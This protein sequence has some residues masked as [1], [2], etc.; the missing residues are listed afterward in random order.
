[1]GNK[2]L[3]FACYSIKTVIFMFSMFIIYPCK[4]LEDVCM[5]VYTCVCINMM[6]IIIKDVRTR[7]E[8]F[9]IY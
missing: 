4:I 5:Y 6:M 3:T 9:V 2:D 8:N 7:K 1:M